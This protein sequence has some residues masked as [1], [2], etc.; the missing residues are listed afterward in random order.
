M[1]MRTLEALLDPH[2]IPDMSVICRGCIE[3]DV[4]LEAV[5]KDENA[6]HEYLDFAKHAKAG[7]LRI[8]SKQG[9]VERL[10]ARREQF[11]QTFGEDPEDFRRN[12]W[13]AKYQGITGLM[14]KLGRT[15]DLRLYNMLSH[16]AHGS[17]WAMETLDGKI[18]EPEKT[19]ATMVEGTYARYLGSSRSF[20]WFVWEPL[21]TPEGEQCKND[22]L[23]V[24]AAYIAEIT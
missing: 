11:D 21:A 6:A 5:I 2:L 23:E 19:L 22:L 3:F 12:S 10:L 24:E 18:T 16:F 17:I 13:C 14:Q 15:T 20:I 7:Y 4:S 1:S 8:L 9:D